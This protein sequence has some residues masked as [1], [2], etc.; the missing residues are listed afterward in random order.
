MLPYNK[1]RNLFCSSSCF[2]SANNVLRKKPSLNTCLSCKKKIGNKSKFCSVRCQKEY[3]YK[4][5]ILQWLD[6]IKP[7]GF[8]AVKRYL[9]ETVGYKCSSC[10]ITEYNGKPIVLELEHKDGNSSNTQINNLCFLC[11]NCHSQTPTYKNR[12]KGKGRHAR[13]QRY[14]EGKSY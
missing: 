9:T 4:S 7:A 3:Q 5:T 12:N 8:G 6:G 1:R 11:P 10:G 2:A 14:R 13:R